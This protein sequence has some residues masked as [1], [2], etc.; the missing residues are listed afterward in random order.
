R[1]RAADPQGECGD[2]SS[3][4]ARA[5]IFRRALGSYR[6]TPPRAELRKSA[7]AVRRRAAECST[8][9]V[10]APGPLHKSAT[11]SIA[12]PRERCAGETL[13]DSRPRI[14]SRKMRE[15]SHLYEEVLDVVRCKHHRRSAAVA[16]QHRALR[17][18]CVGAE[19]PD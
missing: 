12:T 14:S 7:Q 11:I 8:P 4:R 16:Q 6:A 18:R 1:T 9:A 19:S 13:T 10:Q 15:S 5:R 2:R 17:V 3:A